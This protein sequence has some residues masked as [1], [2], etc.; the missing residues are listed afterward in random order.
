MPTAVIAFNDRA[1]L[2]VLESLRNG[3]RTVPSEVSVL[4]YDDS[5]FARLSYVQ[6]SSISQD[7]ATLAAAAVDRAIERAEGA[8]SPSHLVRTPHLVARRTT[9][10]VSPD[11]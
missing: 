7:G 1:A 4:G 6:L 10:P 5:H 8:A 9:A 3:G 11:G 2:G